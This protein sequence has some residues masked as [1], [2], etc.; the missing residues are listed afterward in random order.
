M[1]TAADQYGFSRATS[2]VLTNDFGVSWNA[3]NPAAGISPLTDPFPVRADGTRFDVPPQ[4]SLGSMARVNQGFNFNDFNWRHPRVQRWRFGIQRELSSNM[5]VEVAYWGQWGNRIGVSTRLDYLPEQHWATG[6]TRNNA[7]ATANNRQVANPFRIT[8]FSSIQTSDPLLYQHMSTL[9]GFTSATVQRNRLLREYPHMSS[10]NQSNN[11]IGKA[12]THAMEATFQR[13][14]SR[15]FNLNFSYTRMHQEGFT[16]IENEFERTPRIWWP[17]NTARPHRITA[18]GI[19]QLPFGRG[20]AYLQDGV[21]NHI[22][23]GWQIALTY[24][25]QN[26]PLLGW[27]NLFY[28]GDIDTFEEDATSTPKTLD[29]WFNTGLPFEKVAA[30]Q[31]AAFHTRV[32][33]RFFNGL[34]A[35]GLNQ[36]NGSL[37]REISLVEGVRLQIRADSINLQNRSQMNAPNLSPTS[38]LFGRVTSQTSSLNRFYQIQARIQF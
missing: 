24:E 25:F 1:N 20:R 9:G 33:P 30:N 7:L 5:L 23:G 34:R 15:G 14:F 21:L 26:G 11:P 13:R 17:N 8:N 6:N 3:G 2:T 27:G 32:F 35:D 28:G 31:P 12:R 29:Q 4:A 19:F 38:T 16:T 10:L 22:L 18:T 37:L 36:W